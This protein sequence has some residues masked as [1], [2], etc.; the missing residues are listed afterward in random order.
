MAKRL[1]IFVSEKNSITLDET[2]DPVGS[3]PLSIGYRMN[4]SVAEESFLTETMR[5]FHRLTFWTFML[6]DWSAPTARLTITTMIGI[7]FW[8]LLNIFS[9]GALGLGI[10]DSLSDSNSFVSNA[11]KMN[12]IFLNFMSITTFNWYLLKWRALQ[13]LFSS[14]HRL[15]DN[16]Q[17]E[18]EQD[19]KC[20]IRKQRRLIYLAFF[21][22][23]VL[24][25]SG[26]IIIMTIRVNKIISGDKP[27]QLSTNNSFQTEKIDLFDL[28]PNMNLTLGVLCQTLNYFFCAN[29]SFM[30][31]QMPMM[32]YYYEIQIINLI[33]ANVKRIFDNF[34]AT[35]DSISE[36]F[37]HVWSNYE[38]LSKLNGKIGILCGFPNFLAHA[39]GFAISCGVLYISLKRSDARS[40]P[41]MMFWLITV[42]RLTS[43]IIVASKVGRA[44]VNLAE[45]FA[46][47]SSQNAK[48]LT[49]REMMTANAILQRLQN[50]QIS[51]NLINLYR[52]EY[53][54]LLTKLNVGTSLLLL[55][56]SNN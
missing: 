23:W 40:I 22:T 9:V 18:R 7:G 26:M 19:F 55:I 3:G 50:N 42:A 15:E 12:L 13:R 52:V 38:H 5:P 21:I 37:L 33:K 48:H 43:N 46:K 16:L 34:P 54:L 44:S 32:I 28:I 30:M 41:M 47:L 17:V 49:D 8:Y 36:K 4:S 10:F 56:L 51:I 39:S 29:T 31:E 45:T 20:K 11:G 24:A 27:Q 25:F 53:P 35:D 1:K 6:P 14:F 2:V